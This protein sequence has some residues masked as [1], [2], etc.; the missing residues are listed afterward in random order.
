MDIVTFLIEVNKV[1]PLQTLYIL[2]TCFVFLDILTGMI[3]AWKN[4][5]FK[6]RTMR[7][8]L[9]QSLGELILLIICVG[10][11][12]IINSLGLI[13]FMVLMFMVIKELISVLE[14]LVEVGVRLPKWLVKGL[15]V[16]GDKLDTLDKIKEEE[17]EL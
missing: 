13:I 2:F 8:G 11:A 14:N 7:N 9:F 10:L 4:G 15:Q 12:E 6:S 3:K 5:R 17:G 16:Y 1:V